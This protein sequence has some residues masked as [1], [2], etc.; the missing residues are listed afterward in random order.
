[1]TE[2][3]EDLAPKVVPELTEL[4]KSTDER[5]RLLAVGALGDAGKDGAQPLGEA[6]RDIEESVKREAAQSLVK[7][8]PDAAGAVK[9]LAA[10]VEKRDTDIIGEVVSAL[11]KIGPAAKEALP[12]LES[13]A[14]GENMPEN[15]QLSDGLKREIDKSIRK[16]KGEVRE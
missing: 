15:R 4:S 16:I 1:M 5:L 2:T 8:G 11:G 3:L 7:L 6:L 13:L 10:A 9:H 14:K 12:A